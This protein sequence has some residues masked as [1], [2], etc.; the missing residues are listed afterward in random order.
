MGIRARLRSLWRGMRH[1]AAMEQDLSDELEF[2]IA[3]RASDLADRRGLPPHEARRLARLEFGAIERYKEESR[4][5]VGLTFIDE[6]RGDSRHAFRTFARSKAFTAAAVATLALAIGANTAVFSLIDSV[7]VRLLPVERPEELVEVMLQRPG[8]EP[9]NGFTNPLWEAV[10]DQQ[11][12]FSGVFVWSVP[13]PFAF[14]YGTAS[15]PVTG[16]AVSGDY[17][18]TL[19]VRPAVGRLIST[20][21]DQRGCPPVA[22]L[23]H[24]FW[25]AQFGGAAVV[26]RVIALYRQPFEVVG[27]TEPHFHGLEVGRS[28]D[29]AIPLCA[30]GLFDRRNL[31]SRG[32]WWLSIMGRPH[33]GL[34]LTQLNARLLALSPGVMRAAAG[35]ESDSP[36]QRSFLE[37]RLVAAASAAG[38][39]GLRRRFGEPLQMLMAGV[40]IILLIGCANLAS[41]V[42]AKGTARTQEMAVRTALGASRRRLVQQLLTESLA[43]ATLGAALGLL[44]AKWGTAFL[45]RSLQVVVDV[46]LDARVLAFTAVVAMATGVLVGLMPAVRLTGRSVF[47]AMKTRSVAIGDR[48]SRARAGKWIVGAQLALS[49]ILLIGGGLLLRSFTALLSLDPGFDRHGVIVASARVPN[50]AADTVTLTPERRSAALEEIAVRIAG[51]PGVAAVARSHTTPIGGG[52][53]YSTVVSDAAN[54]PSGESAAAYFNF[55]TPG[56]FTTLRMPLVAGRDFVP[57]DTR[58]SPS[59]AIVNESAARRFFPGLEAIGRTF[60]RPR[61]EQ[62]FQVVGI[63]KDAKYES[64]RDVP[65]P[66]IF[67]PATQA[68]AGGDANDFVIRTSV[69]PSTMIAAIERTAATVTAEVALTTRTMDEQIENELAQERLLAIL[70]GFFGALALLLSAIGLYGVLNYVVTDRQ[71]E[72][73]VRLALGAVPGSI[74]RLVMR[75]MVVVIAAGIAAGLAA[76]LASV[77]LLQSMLY[78]L[79]PHDALTTMLAV[80]LLSGVCLLAAFLPARRAAGLPPVTALRAE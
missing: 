65:P 61:D 50:F 12:V 54:A 3:A 22:V 7:M 58:Q 73:G 43:L 27:V 42:L 26:G 32:R 63:V 11:D 21:D 67:V 72:F 56:Y 48:R 70:A 68:P 15:R 2:H 49:L 37:R 74:L 33:P 18:R 38:P 80:G 30:S 78:G 29:V 28:F 31:E 10:R 35:P 79:A 47:A 64:L 19:G 69:P 8:Q 76:A 60:R 62:A 59:V 66:T 77:H 53:W 45:L 23:G 14:G 39:S 17:F 20:R 16:I 5:S 36:N 51:I 41:L 1:R 9:G 57:D 13:Q 24:D 75:E 40:V 55:V 34:T 71:A 25:Q 44:V 6:L 4:G 46:S 52:N